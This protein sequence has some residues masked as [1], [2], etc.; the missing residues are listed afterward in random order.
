MNQLIKRKQFGG[1]LVSGITNTLD[2][3][4]AKMD[5]GSLAKIKPTGFINKMTNFA[6]NTKV[7]SF[8]QNAGSGL[9]S[10]GLVGA[11]ANTITSFIPEKDLST[12]KR[13][14]LA[15]GLDK[16]YDA[17][18][19]TVAMIP[20]FGQAAAGIMAVNKMLSKG[21]DAMGV[22][23][24]RMC[25]CAGTKVFKSNGDIVNIEDL[26][27]ED[28]IIGWDSNAKQIVQQS[29]GILTT[30]V[31]KECV[32]LTLK[33]NI[34][35]RCSIDH[36]ILSDMAEKA[37]MKTINHKRIGVRQW[38]FRRAD[39]LKVGNFVGLAN[40]INYFG[41]K[42]VKEA[43]LIGLLIGD[44]TYTKGN[45]CMLSTADEDTWNYLESNNLGVLRNITKYKKELRKYRIINGM[46]IMRNAGIVYQCKSNKTLPKNLYEYDKESICDLIAGLF[47]TDGSI[48]CNTKKKQFSI[49]FYQTN[50]NLLKELQI[51]LHKLGIFSS[52]GKRRAADFNLGGKIRHSKESYRL[53]IHGKNSIINFYNNIKLRIKYKQ[54]QLD[55]IYNI[56]IKNRD[57]EHNIISGAKQCKIL[58]IKYI[59]YQTVYNL[60]VD[61][62]HTYL[63]NGIITHNTRADA[64]LDSPFLK[65]TPLGLANAIGAKKTHTFEGDD[66][67]N[68]QIGSSYGGSLD[69]FADTELQSGK[70]YGLF[71][72]KQYK[73]ANRFIDESQRQ[74]DL[75]TEIATDARNDF[76]A[77]SNPFLENRMQISRTGGFNNAA[78][79]K[80]GMKIQNIDWAKELVKRMRSSQLQSFEQG[81]KMNIIPTGALHKEL[82]HI[83]QDGITKKGI[84]V[85]VQSE[86]GE[87][88]QTAEIEKE[89]IIL[90][91]DLT[92]AMEQYRDQYNGSPNIEDKEQAALEA[93]KILVNEL[94]NNTIDKSKL[95]KSI[96]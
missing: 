56:V 55:D 39:E 43:Y 4:L 33:Y 13:G 73:K 70:K 3:S 51:Q 83:D 78:V 18:M 77:S 92:T 35:L 89:E 2:T 44:G 47:D 90:H 81:G 84:P 48:C 10:G 95:I 69:R 34:K 41:D 96:E 37:K 24:D 57:S 16:G 74:Q 25:V 20:G 53:A 30:P 67:T 64:I 45:S 36:P 91:L 59:G 79:G 31:Q 46:Q 61:D 6:Q 50:Y 5:T 65:M 17:A 62:C 26:K 94:L 28:G 75:M 71:S 29:I 7:G 72:R 52:I 82:H 23:T 12:A 85:V 9:S 40:D 38:K 63:A 54:K 49:T 68:E 27:I 14:N 15:K 8:L 76:A 86:G 66:A 60:S 21:L 19:S 88:E 42:K 1:S 32:E 22:G 11:A 93:G 58:D 80:E 87:I